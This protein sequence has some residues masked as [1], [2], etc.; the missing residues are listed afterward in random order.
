MF[1]LIVYYLSIALGAFAYY[2]R[3]MNGFVI[4]IA[5]FCLISAIFYFFD[6]WAFIPTIIIAIAVV[7]WIGNRQIPDTENSETQTTGARGAVIVFMSATL[8]YCTGMTGGLHSGTVLD[9]ETKQPLAGAVVTIITDGYY[10]VPAH[11]VSDKL[12]HQTTTT[13]KNG[14]YR[15]LPWIFLPQG[16]YIMR[17]SLVLADKE[18]YAR[19]SKPEYNSINTVVLMNTEKV[20]F[21]YKIEELIHMIEEEKK[22]ELTVDSYIRFATRYYASRQYAKFPSTNKIANKICNIAVDTYYSIKWTK[23]DEQELANFAGLGSTDTE[24][25][26]YVFIRNLEKCKKLQNHYAKSGPEMYEINISPQ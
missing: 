1:F 6:H 3:R 19:G 12:M 4:G 9:W 11:P 20:A 7:A 14:R 21:T 16:F 18:G 8:A 17:K 22:L 25:N 23:K 26:S 13:D 2:G 24:N 10:P 15:S 5:Y